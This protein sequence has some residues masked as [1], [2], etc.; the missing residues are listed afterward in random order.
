MAKTFALTMPAGLPIFRR[1]GIAFLESSVHLEVNGH[2]QFRTL[3]PKTDREVRTYFD[4]W[5]QG[6]DNAPRRFHGFSRLGY[7][8]CFTFKWRENRL[9]HRFYGFLCNPK[10]VSDKGFRLCVLIYHAAKL[11]WNT[12]DA[13]LDRVNRLRDDLRVTEAIAQKYPEHRGFKKWN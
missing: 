13:I 11:T 5:L 3:K 6:N 2:N 1:R 10:P 9:E 7:R 12:D 4:Y 8:E